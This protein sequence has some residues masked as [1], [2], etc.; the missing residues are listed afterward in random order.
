[1][2]FSIFTLIVCI[3]LSKLID[4]FLVP[5]TYPGGSR[6]TFQHENMMMRRKYSKLSHNNNKNNNNGEEHSEFESILG[7]GTVSS[8]PYHERRSRRLV[9]IQKPDGSS[10]ADS[11]R[12]QKS[13]L[14][15]SIAPAEVESET[16][17]SEEGEEEGEEEVAAEGEATTTTT[18]TPLPS[19]PSDEFSKK[20]KFEE[21]SRLSRKLERFERSASGNTDFVPANPEEEYF[22]FAAF[23]VKIFIPVV[24]GGVAARWTYGKAR[25]Y[26]SRRAEDS[27]M[28]YANEMVYHDGDFEEMRMCHNDFATKLVWLGPMK[29]DRM[30]KAY[31]EVYA[32][33]KVVSPQSISSLSY[34]FSIYKFSEARAA[35]TLVELCLRMPDKISSTGKLLFFGTHILKS[36]EAKAKLAPIRKMLASSYR[37]DVEEI[38][39]SGDEIL[40]NSQRAMGEAAYRTAV[41]AAG[42]DQKKLTVGWEVLGLDEETATNI[43]EDVQGKGFISEKEAK[44]GRGGGQMKYD[45][46]GRRLDDEGNVLPGQEDIG[47]DDDDS[48][49]DETTANAY[50]CGECGYTLFVAQG[51][52]FKFFG[53]GFTCPECGATKDKFS[54]LESDDEDDEDVF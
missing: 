3:D 18:T 40:E 14:T 25:G 47:D 23:F 39:L 44:Y 20:F 17:V 36:A 10:M 22:D 7:E 6:W 54:V 49:P 38:G 35:E 30:I 37:D 51:R 29:T 5:Y 43:F 41:S 46:K 48:G 13:S 52:D 21:E 33:K 34:V 24:A 45:A 9:I 16:E 4:G 31:L 8:L 15:S 53:D 50:V 28:S 42:K 32:K 26:L 27:L 19:S 1:M 2:R 12:L 11:S